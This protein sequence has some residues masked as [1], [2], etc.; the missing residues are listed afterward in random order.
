VIVE[1]VAGNMGCVPPRAGF[2]EALRQLTRDDGALLIFDE[3]ITGFR[4]GRGGAQEHYG[5]R[6]DLTCLG[7]VIGGGLPVAAYG[8]SAELMRLVAP[9]GPVYQAGTLSGNPLAMAAGCALLDLLEAAPPYAY[10][11]RLG[12]RLAAGLAVAAADAGAPCAVNRVG[13]M[14]TPFVG[15]QEVGDFAAA[16]AADRAR[17]AAVHRAWL[18][19]GVL[20]PP[21]QFET[22]F[23]SAAHSDS[24]VDH[25][26]EVFAAALRA[27]VAVA[28]VGG[29]AA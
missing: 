10:L 21:S 25:T 4:L 2:L 20:W 13:S 1:P 22:G 8:G 28:S 26:V 6:P 9:A 29:P 12:A 24:D 5:V 19:A 18:Q 15:V 7:K 17:F 3:V 16:G 23:L 11:E 14:V 27:G